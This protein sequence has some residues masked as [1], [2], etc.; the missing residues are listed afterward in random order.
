MSEIESTTPIII[1][2]LLMLIMG[3]VMMALLAFWI[4]MLIDCIKN[5]PDEGNNKLIWVLVIIFTQLLGAVIYYFVQ[6][7]ERLQN[8]KLDGSN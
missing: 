7:R 3:S 1:P 6:R 4:W 2:I 8:Y 5:E